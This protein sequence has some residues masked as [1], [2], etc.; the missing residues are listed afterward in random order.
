M[1]SVF[2]WCYIKVIGTPRIFFE[3]NI[4]KAAFSYHKSK[5]PQKYNMPPSAIA[6][7]VIV[8]TYHFIPRFLMVLW[9]WFNPKIY[10]IRWYFNV[11]LSVTKIRYFFPKY[12]L[13][14][15]KHHYQHQ[16]SIQIDATRWYFKRRL[17][18]WI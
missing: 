16:I 12:N 8:M 7:A 9:R 14:F 17:N 2:S 11:P 10:E 5:F 1:A 6:K 13:Q 18:L 4:L 15:W 3:I